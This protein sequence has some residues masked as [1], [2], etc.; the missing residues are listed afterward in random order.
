MVSVALVVLISAPVLAQSNFLDN[1]AKPPAP[2]ERALTPEEKGDILMARKMYR[3]AV[4]V[5]REGP[6]DSPILH[7][8]V[9]IAFHQMIELNVAKKEYEKA[10]KLNPQ[11]A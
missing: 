9:G 2:V 1:P 6:A 4:E 3:E 7:N 8:K 11:Y 5:Y 10:V